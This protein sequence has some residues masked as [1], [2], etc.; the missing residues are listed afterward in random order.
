[1]SDVKY[2]SMLDLEQMETVEQEMVGADPTVDANAQPAPIPAGKY[3][4]KVRHRQEE[5]G[6]QWIGMETGENS[7]KPGEQYYATELVCEVAENPVN[8]KETYGRK[9]VLFDRDMRTL[10]RENG[11]CEVVALLQGLDKGP[12]VANGP[13][14]GTRY[15]QILTRTLRSEPLVGVEV[16]WEARFY[17]KDTKTEPEKPIRGMK[18]FPKLG[19]KGGHNP[20]VIAGGVESTARVFV[21]RWIKVSELT[22]GT[23]ALHGVATPPPLPVE[24]AKPAPKPLSRKA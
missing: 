12:E 22:G 2:L 11:T 20:V 17:D 7:K 13:Q 19:E 24:H 3:L 15:A 10:L 1:M 16:D 18:N 23:A 9:F 8:P 4:V 6:K 21:R 14:K 5:E